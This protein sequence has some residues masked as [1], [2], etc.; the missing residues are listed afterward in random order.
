MD[1]N[2]ISNSRLGNFPALFRGGNVHQSPF[3]TKLLC[4]PAG[5]PLPLCLNT[6]LILFIEGRTPC[7]DCIQQSRVSETTPKPGIISLLALLMMRVTYLVS[8]S[9]KIVVIRRT[10]NQTAA[11]SVANVIG[12]WRVQ[13]SFLLTFRLHLFSSLALHFRVCH[14]SQPD[15]NFWAQPTL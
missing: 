5:C 15:T 6:I 9:F 7:S 10:C 4:C 14:C 1:G 12:L 3:C 8:Q 13:S 2:K 11:A